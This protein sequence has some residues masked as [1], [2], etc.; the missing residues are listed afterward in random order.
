[1]ED[2]TKAFALRV[3]RLCAALPRNA[4]AQ[5]IAGQLR[6]SGTSVGANYRASR[7]SRS[8]AEMRSKLAT[9]EEEADESAFWLELIMEQGHLA[10]DRVQPLWQEANEITAMMVSSIKTL[11]KQVDRG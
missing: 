10:D 5:M 9:V 8:R 7:R 1:M 11:R 3:L 4:E 6:R 2:R